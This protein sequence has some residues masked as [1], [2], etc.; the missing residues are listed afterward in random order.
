MQIYIITG[1]KKQNI[2]KKSPSTLGLANLKIIFINNKKNFDQKK[3]KN[4]FFLYFL[5]SF[6]DLYATLNRVS[7][8][9]NF[10]SE[11]VN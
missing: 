8:K 9:N 7:R 10:F 6:D 3:Y 5:Q 11:V 2:S 1:T 4:P